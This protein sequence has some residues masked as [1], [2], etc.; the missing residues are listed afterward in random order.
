[1][2]ESEKKVRQSPTYEEFSDHRK[3]VFESVIIQSGGQT[4]VDRTALDFAIE[5]GLDHTGWCPRGRAAEDGRIDDRYRLR[6]TESDE[7]E[8]RTRTN[9]CTSDATVIFSSSASIAGGTLLTKTICEALAKPCLH[10]SAAEVEPKTAGELLHQFIV[11][12]HVSRLNVAGPRASEDLAAA[13]Y[14]RTVLQTTWRRDL[15]AD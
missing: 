14:A 15:E 11:R 3:A 9:I 6:E 2:A 1:M 8:V 4:G 13:E 10:L 5:M 7:L 12:H